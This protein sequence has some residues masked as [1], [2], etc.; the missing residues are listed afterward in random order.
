MELTALL[1]TPTIA[2][3]TVGEFYNLYNPNHI[4]ATVLDNPRK[5]IMDK[6]TSTKFAPVS[7]NPGLAQATRMCREFNC[8]SHTTGDS[9]KIV[10]T[11][12][13]KG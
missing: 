3:C 8:E 13:G 10:L 4:N 7:V 2:T 12:E 5:K 9:R 11:P 1:N 6:I